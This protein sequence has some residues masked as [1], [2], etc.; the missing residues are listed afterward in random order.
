M[1]DQSFP[2]AQIALLTVSKDGPLY[3]ISLTAPPDN[4]FSLPFIKAFHSALDAIESDLKSGEPAALITVNSNGKIY[5]NGLMLENVMGIG[6]P[7]F[8]AYQNFLERFLTFRLP[9]I[10]A[11]DGLRI[12]LS[13]VKSVLTLARRH[14]F[15]GGCMFALA[16]DYRVMRQDKGFICMNESALAVSF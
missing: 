10:A 2:T 16:H 6:R 11:I 8:I 13:M 4:R 9:T 14:A 1:K 15:A 7:Y 3:V 12:L 5:S